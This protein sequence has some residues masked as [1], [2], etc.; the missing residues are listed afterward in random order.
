MKASRTLTILLPVL[1]TGQ[2]LYSQTSYNGKVNLNKKNN[3]FNLVSS[4]DSFNV[5]IDKKSLTFSNPSNF[6]FV[7]IRNNNY[8]LV[9]EGA[10]ISIRDAKNQIEFSTGLIL[11][12][13][14]KKNKQIILKD[15][16]G[17]IVLDA[18]FHLK[19]GIS[20]FNIA[21]FDNKHKIELLSY[22][23]HYLYFKSK[24]LKESND[25]PYIYFYIF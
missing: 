16:E 6:S 13:V 2:L 14:S 10:S 19:R 25:T 12:P 15:E 21:I 18:K 4:S 8:N 1:I 24:R 17:K 5:K 7:K 3:S 22:A 20:D 23:T 11:Y 9:K